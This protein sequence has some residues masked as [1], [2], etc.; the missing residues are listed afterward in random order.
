MP[1]NEHKKNIINDVIPPKRSIRNIQLD[2]Q[3]KIP[4]QKKEKEVVINNPLP[5]EP[6]RIGFTD[7]TKKSD[8]PNPQLNP[9]YDYQYDEPRK[10]SKKILYLGFFSIVTVLILSISVFFKSAEIRITPKQEI[11]T[12]NESLTAKKD[13]TSGL[14]FQIV[15]ITKDVEKKIEAKTEEKVEKK[16]KGKIV[17]YNAYSQN[18]LKLI[19]TTRFQSTEG[20]IFRLIKPLTV[21]GKQIKDGKTIPGSIEAIV[22]A[23]VPGDIYN[24]SLKDFTLPSYKNNP[25]YETIYARSKTEMTGGFSGIQKIISK[26]E[27]NS[28]DLELEKNL[29]ES[30]SKDII[31][32]IPSNFVLYVDSLS[33]TFE[34]VTQGVSKNQDESSFAVLRK[35]GTGSGIIFDKG[36]L[37]LALVNKVIPIAVNDMIKIINL[38]DLHFSYASSSLSF[39]PNTTSN[40]SFVLT[41]EPHFVWIFDQNKLKSN[42]LGLSKNDAKTVIA[43]YGTIRE[44]WITTF[45]FWIQTIPNDQKR[46]K[47]INTLEESIKTDKTKVD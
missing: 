3:R 23:D 47:L 39:D 36:S 18:P 46:V 33:Y 44:A 21:P 16:A 17:V 6:M 5:Q 22:E 43:T 20:L 32:Q 1:K 4:E 10:K 34:S 8:I 45:P 14:G 11:K 38:E 27:L 7:E 40:I 13:Q 9:T 12:I 37:S 30:I 25:R 35:K 28:A 19:A 2:N 42:L 24:I 31:S 15:T 26:E 29:K 41:G